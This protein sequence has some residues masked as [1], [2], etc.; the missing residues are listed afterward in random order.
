MPWKPTSVVFPYVKPT[1]YGR[2]SVVR[3]ARVDLAEHLVGAGARVAAPAGDRVRRED[4]VVLLDQP[5]LLARDAVDDAAAGA[6][7]RRDRRERATGGG[8]SL[9]TADLV[10]VWARI[11]AR[12]AA[13]GAAG[14]AV[15]RGAHGPSVRS[16]RAGPAAAAVRPR[17]RRRYG[18]RDDGDPAREHG[19]CSNDGGTDAQL[20]GPP[21]PAV[22][23][24]THVELSP[25]RPPAWPGREQVIGGPAAVG[26]GPISTGSSGPGV[27]RGA[28]IPETSVA[29]APK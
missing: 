16:I 28:P 12:F 8:G 5:D 27:P 26:D 1:K 10:A 25:C 22:A 15:G 13:W 7:V 11:A 21:K 23:A 3:P 24:L 29:G 17:R 6:G 20:A 2:R 14:R 18:G 19:H 4:V 9:V